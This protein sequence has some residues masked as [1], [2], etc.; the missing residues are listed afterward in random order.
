ML[1]QLVPDWQIKKLLT[2][3]LIAC[4]PALEK[5][6]NKGSSDISVLGQFLQLSPCKA[7]HPH[8]CLQVT[9]T[10]FLGLSLFLLPSGFQETAYLVVLVA[11]LR[12]AWSI[13]LQRLWR[14]SCLLPQLLVAKNTVTGPQICRIL[15]RQVLVY[16]WILLVAKALHGYLK[17]IGNE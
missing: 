15:L 6:A 10:G 13:H 11:G 17:P 9:A 8:V 4:G 16:V 14:M 7:G 2:Y 3:L 12:R 5:A 1:T